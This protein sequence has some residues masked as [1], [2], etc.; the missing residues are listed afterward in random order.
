[1]RHSHEDV[2]RQ[3]EGWGFR[4]GKIKNGR[5]LMRGPSGGHVWATAASSVGAGD[6]SVVEEASK[7]LNV[8]VERFWEQNFGDAVKGQPSQSKRFASSY[9]AEILRYLDQLPGSALEDT[10]LGV[11]HA[12][13]SALGERSG[14]HLSS[15]GSAIS[16]LERD[17]RLV[18]IYGHRSLDG[19][20]CRIKV[21]VLAEP[22]V[23]SAAA[24]VDDIE[25]DRSGSGGRSADYADRIAEEREHELEAHIAHLSEEAMLW[26]DMA[27]DL[28]SKLADATSNMQ[29]SDDGI[30][31]YCAEELERKDVLIR[32]RERQLARRHETISEQQIAIS[33]LTK[34]L[35]SARQ[36]ISELQQRQSK[37]DKS[38]A[39][40]IAERNALRERVQQQDNDIRSLNSTLLNVQER[41]FL[42]VFS[43]I[44]S[45]GMKS[46]VTNNTFESLL[47]PKDTFF[48]PDGTKRH[49]YHSIISRVDGL[50]FPSL[51]FEVKN[52]PEM[53]TIDEQ[54]LDYAQLRK[55]LSAQVGGWYV[56]LLQF[57]MMLEDAGASVLVDH[58]SD[59]VWRVTL[60]EPVELVNRGKELLVHGNKVKLLDPNS[61]VYNVGVMETIVRGK[62]IYLS[63]V[64]I[65][66]PSYLYKLGQSSNH[67]NRLLH[68]NDLLFSLSPLDEKYSVLLVS[69]EMLQRA[70]S[71]QRV[72]RMLRNPGRHYGIRDSSENLDAYNLAVG[73]TLLGMAGI[74]KISSD[75]NDPRT[76][77]LNDGEITDLYGRVLMFVQSRGQE[78]ESQWTVHPTGRK[79]WL[80]ELRMTT[81]DDEIFA[82]LVFA[83]KSHS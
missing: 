8:T 34:D 23:G 40:A 59:A 44:L 78:K 25:I 12:V 73:A 5:V 30:L 13:W 10:R 51:I 72:A 32:W 27:L 62:E 35:E 17:G 26:E 50:V 63:S 38:L 15:C 75:K 48:H 33:T 52:A 22:P 65:L 43:S 24:P 53:Q 9:Q 47:T 58:Y 64:R 46:D 11:A 36:S 42:S 18:S 60:D 19:Q 41:M 3:L 67:T 61:V 28:E 31:D 83:A 70:V 16:S 55:D 69:H 82:S 71:T 79:D 74:R 29:Q 7:L 80:V 68:K 66:Q 56:Q 76:L 54:P 81:Q 14:K 1:M 37:L 57:C 21:M 4:P 6:T 20:L 49:E 2:I 39:A 77:V 45:H